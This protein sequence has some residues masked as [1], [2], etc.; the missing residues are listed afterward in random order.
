[1]LTAVPT[2]HIAQSVVTVTAIDWRIVA[3]A[4]AAFAAWLTLTIRPWHASRRTRRR[5][6]TVAAS[7]LVT[8][9]VIPSVFPYDHLFMHEGAHHVSA[10]APD[11]EASAIH[12]SHCHDTPGS[13]ADAPLAAGPGQFLASGPLMPVPALLSVLLVLATPLLAGTTLR[14]EIRPPLRASF[15]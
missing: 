7:V 14:P 1:M 4:V 6:V 15:A 9:A 10:A 5:S 3:L 2:L 13:C 8:L 11:S 12:A